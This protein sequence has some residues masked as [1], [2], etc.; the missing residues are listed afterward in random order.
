MYLGIWAEK[1]FLNIGSKKTVNF[2][3]EDGKKSPKIVTLTLTP[4]SALSV[5]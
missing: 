5:M 2:L 1:M 4:V 3:Q